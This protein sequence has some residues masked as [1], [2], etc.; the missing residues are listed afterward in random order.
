MDNI[1]IFAST[2]ETMEAKSTVN[3]KRFLLMD[4]NFN[5]ICETDYLDTITFEIG[6]IIKRMISDKDVG[7]CKSYFF[8]IT[9][10]FKT[11]KITPD[12]MIKAYLLIKAV[13]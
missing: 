7:S 1:D 11:V 6:K 8:E 10:I 3:K 13:K 4:D 9:D 2:Y 5:T 12:D